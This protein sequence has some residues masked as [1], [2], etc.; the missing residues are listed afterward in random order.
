M[1][2]NIPAKPFPT[3]CPETPRRVWGLMRPT[4]TMWDRSGEEPDHGKRL[5]KLRA[6]LPTD[7]I[8]NRTSG[9]HSPG[10]NP[11]M[12]WERESSGSGFGGSCTRAKGLSAMERTD[13]QTLLWLRTGYTGISG[14]RR[15]LQNSHRNEPGKEEGEGQLA[16]HFG[17][18]ANSVHW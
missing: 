3:H 8:L 14:V 17:R 18:A 10:A 16:T 9:C 4:Q 12:A 13:F 7:A 1:G 2:A 5:R 6:V 11:L 15:G